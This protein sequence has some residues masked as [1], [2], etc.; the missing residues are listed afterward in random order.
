[1]DTPVLGRVV[2]A[3]IRALRTPIYGW[4]DPKRILE[5]IISVLVDKG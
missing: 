5:I 2:E 3:K 4:F 1:L